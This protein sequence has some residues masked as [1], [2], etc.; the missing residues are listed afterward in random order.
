MRKSKQQKYERQQKINSLV[1]GQKIRFYFDRYK[2][3]FSGRFVKKNDD[4]T[5][6]ITYKLKDKRVSLV[7][8]KEDFR[9]EIP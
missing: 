8:T 7:I 4:G 2:N 1:V 3:V 9:F 5:F 6:T